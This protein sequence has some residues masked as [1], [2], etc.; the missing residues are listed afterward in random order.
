MEKKH[1]ENALPGTQV[2]EII[3]LSPFESSATYEASWRT[4]ETQVAPFWT[5]FPCGGYSLGATS[6]SSK[7][8]RS[9]FSSVASRNFTQI[10]SGQSAPQ[11]APFVHHKAEVYS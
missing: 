8:W 3:V 10:V 4:C 1:G 2:R 9:L 11:A 5:V 6:L 7:G